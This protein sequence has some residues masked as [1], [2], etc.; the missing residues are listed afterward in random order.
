LCFYRDIKA[1]NI[2]V[3]KEGRVQLA[4]FG[5]SA[6]LNTEGVHDRS[7]RRQTFVGTPS[8]MAPEVM[9]QVHGYD[10]RADVWSFGVTAIELAHGKAPYDGMPPMKVLLLILKNPPPT[11]EIGGKQLKFSAAF[12]DLVQ[13]CLQKDPTQRPSAK[14]LLEHP[15]FADAEKHKQSGTVVKILETLPPLEQRFQT[16][17]MHIPRSGVWSVDK[18]D[19]AALKEAPKSIS[20]DFSTDDVGESP[21]AKSHSD[22]DDDGAATSKTRYD[23]SGVDAELVLGDTG[24]LARSQ[25]GRSIMENGCKDPKSVL[26]DATEGEVTLSWLEVDVSDLAVEDQIKIARSTRALRGISHPNIISVNKSGLSA[27]TGKFVS[28]TEHVLPSTIESSLVAN[29]PVPLAMAQQWCSQ[30]VSALVLLH[31][32]TPP[33]VHGALRCDHLIVDEASSTCKIFVARPRL[34][35]NQ[36]KA[37]TFVAYIPPELYDNEEVTPKVDIYALGMCLLHMLTGKEPYEECKHAP[38]V[39]K[40]VE[41]GILPAAI[42]EITDDV[43]RAFVE[44]CLQA[45]QRPA[46]AELLTHEF[47]AGVAVPPKVALSGGKLKD[48]K[49]SSISICLTLTIKGKQKEI[50]FPFDMEKDTAN[51]IASEMVGDVPV[52]AEG[53]MALCNAIQDTIL[54]L[55]R[56]S[57]AAE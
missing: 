57:K 11:L 34:D 50:A 20:W 45:E 5:V 30:I 26:Y 1:S 17:E 8:W 23:L 18:G 53:G 19:V 14:A 40:R 16:T 46:A 37:V 35:E 15:F 27:A 6:A 36:R 9:E 32:C 12:H 54:R 7:E 38:E 31:S 28:I 13:L 43:A 4:D 25:E 29:G 39:Y 52:L 48:V 10:W 51:D 2:L 42:E 44:A 24:S 41:D 33:I 47:L 3:D 21:A 22:S 56:E 49:G 55:I